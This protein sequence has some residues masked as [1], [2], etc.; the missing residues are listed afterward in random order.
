MAQDDGR[1]VLVTHCGAREV[2]REE[3]DTVEAPA[4]TATW[5]P[6]RH[7]AVVDAVSGSLI[8]AGFAVRAARFALARSDQR[9]FAT[10]DLAAELAAGVSVAVGV[11]NSTDKSFPLGFCAGSRVFV[12]DNLAFRAELLVK[13][14][15]TKFGRDRF[16]EAIARAVEGLAAFKEQEAARVKRLSE[17]EVTDQAA[18]SLMLRAY[19]A[20]VVPVIKEWRE[21]AFDEFRPRTGWSLF[22]VFT[23]ALGPQAKRDPQ[24]HALLTMRLGRLLDPAPDPVAEAIEAVEAP[25]SVA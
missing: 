2:S 7:G 20:G 12:C 14:K 3:L 11:R 5:Y 6:V 19:E 22:N 24:R 4:A 16:L 17:L 1:A 21:P 10:F 15:H 23:R 9:M 8:A 18:E 13:R 25:N